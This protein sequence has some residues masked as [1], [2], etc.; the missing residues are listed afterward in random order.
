MRITSKDIQ[1][2]KKIKAALAVGQL[3]FLINLNLTYEKTICLRLFQT[4]C[5]KQKT[6]VKILKKLQL[7]QMRYCKSLIVK[8][9]SV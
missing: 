3:L 6:A 7:L 2:N 8:W 9:L 4:L 5:Q 1:K